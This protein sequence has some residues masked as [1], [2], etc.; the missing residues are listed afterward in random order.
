MDITL[1]NHLIEIAKAKISDDDPSHDMLHA[2]KVLETVK[3]LSSKEGG[4]LDVLVP[5]ALFHDVVCYQKNHPNSH[6]SAKESAELTASILKELN[7]YPQ[8]KIAN[9]YAII[10]ECSFSKGITSTSIEGKILQDA[11]KLEAT[12][13]ISI[14][15]TFCSA[16]QMKKK[17]YHPED[18]FCI[19]RKPDGKVYALD[20][21]FDRLLVVKDLMHTQT[22]KKIAERRTKVLQRFL[23]DF[24]LE[25][26]SGLE[27]PVKTNVNG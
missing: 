6:L 9:V 16:G 19:E 15:R 22:A 25:L 4:D 10:N 3:Y 13:I 5:A 17:L 21:F 11:D 20:L 27:N 1:E 14:M 23:E 8:E 26:Y 2:M 24:S 12:G 18:P 7:N